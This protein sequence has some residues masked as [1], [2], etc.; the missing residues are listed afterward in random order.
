MGGLHL[1]KDTQKTE[2]GEEE[3][4]GREKEREK[5]RGQVGLPA[6]NLGVGDLTSGGEREGGRGRGR[7]EKGGRTERL[8]TFVPPTLSSAAVKR[9]ISYLTENGLSH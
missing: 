8:S 2:G 7:G 6:L 9:L 1:P 3:E 4:K 5:G